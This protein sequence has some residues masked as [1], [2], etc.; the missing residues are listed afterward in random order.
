VASALDMLLEQMR[1]A[2]LNQMFGADNTAA[3]RVGLY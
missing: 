2:P 3:R 1:A